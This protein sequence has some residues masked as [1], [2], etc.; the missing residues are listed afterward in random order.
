MSLR[1][2]TI[3]NENNPMLLVFPFRKLSIY[4]KNKNKLMRFILLKWHFAWHL[5]IVYN[6][7]IYLSSQS[8][9]RGF[10]SWKLLS[11]AFDIETIKGIFVNYMFLSANVYNE[12]RKTSYNRFA[13]LLLIAGLKNINQCK[14]KLFD[15]NFIV[16]LRAHKFILVGTFNQF[17]RAC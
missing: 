12:S 16:V 6:G 4:C 15:T 2:N 3:F 7:F 13:R 5:V 11:L 1:L 10:R 9:R 8:S 17:S 14:K